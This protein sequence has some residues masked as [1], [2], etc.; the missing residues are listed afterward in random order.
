MKL[1]AEPFSPRRRINWFALVLPIY[2][3]VM[4]GVLIYSCHEYTRS[5][6]AAVDRYAKQVGVE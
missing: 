1:I 5:V 4:L 2:F 3:A 6:D